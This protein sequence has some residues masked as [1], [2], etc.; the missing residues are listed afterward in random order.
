MRELN[1]SGKDVLVT[2]ASSGIGRAVA[3]GFAQ[4][5][6]DLTIL[7][8]NEQIFGA[9][10]EISRDV[11]RK[12]T[13]LLC[14]IAK[15]NDV[16]KAF[17]SVSKIDVLVNNAGIER[18][19]PLAESGKEVETHFGAVVD[20]NLLGT[21]YVTREAIGLMPDGGKILFTASTWS[22]TAF[23]QMSGYC[24]SKHA[25]LG[26][27]RALAYELG[28]RRINVNCICPGWVKTDQSFGSVIEVSKRTGRTL[29]DVS[30]EL[31]NKQAIRGMLE[32]E[33]MINGYLFLASEL[34]RDITGQSL[35]VDR[36]EVMS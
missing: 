19:T 23:A 29:E 26:F 30:D 4:C 34:A 8:Q 32:P 16:S 17:A 22:K 14:D 18:V 5:G 10:E 31:L 3:Q 20:V 7:A 33:D 25:V 28:P 36:G 9:A 11:G 12:V 21:Y 13:P 15:R 27:A 1:F 24:A 2:G 6:A 35:H